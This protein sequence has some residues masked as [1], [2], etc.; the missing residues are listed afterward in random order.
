MLKAKLGNKITFLLTLDQKEYTGVI[1]AVKT[2]NNLERNY[3][4]DYLVTSDNIIC[5]GD[6]FNVNLNKNILRFYN[7]VNAGGYNEKY[8]IIGGFNKFFN[9]QG[10]WVMDSEIIEVDPEIYEE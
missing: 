4:V 8:D 7:S 10:Y 9:K 5:N 2:Y 6:L 3:N 1:I